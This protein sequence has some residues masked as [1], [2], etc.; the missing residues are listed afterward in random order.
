M[1]ESMKN[2]RRG[3]LLMVASALLVSFG[4]MFWK[5]YHTEGFPALFLGLVLYALGALIMLVAYRYGSLSVLQPMLCLSYVFAIFI[6]VFILHEHMTP[7]KLSGICVVIF[8]VLMI[9]GGDTQKNES[10]VLPGGGE[11]AK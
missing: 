10:N 6:A 9:A 3:I 8:G 1:I 2:N 4:Q 5:M 7:M 11:K